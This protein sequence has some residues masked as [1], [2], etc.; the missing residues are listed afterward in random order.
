MAP[1]GMCGRVRDGLFFCPPV[2]VGLPFFALDEEGP[3][4]W[5]SLGF[6]SDYGPFFGGMEG[7]KPFF[8]SRGQTFDSS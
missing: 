3:S 6:A 4:F 1:T 8:P 2:G 7:S 5:L